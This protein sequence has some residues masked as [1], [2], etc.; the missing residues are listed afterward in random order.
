MIQIQI[1]AKIV[2]TQKITK[3]REIETKTTDVLP[4]VGSRKACPQTKR[5]LSQHRTLRPG[6]KKKRKLCKA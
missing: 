2:R 5:K 3:I 6:K 4:E 1:Q